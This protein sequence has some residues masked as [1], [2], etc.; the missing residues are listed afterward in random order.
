LLEDEPAI[1]G[2]ATTKATARIKLTVRIL[3]VSRLVAGAARRFRCR[4]DNQTLFPDVCAKG[5]NGFVAPQICFVA[6]RRT[7]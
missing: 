6:K 5:E 2:P 3:T 7:K 1:D 4:L